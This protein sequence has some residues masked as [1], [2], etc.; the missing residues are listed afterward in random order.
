MLCGLYY[1][2]SFQNCKEA[3]GGFFVEKFGLVLAGGG[4]KGAYQIGVWRAMHEMGIEKLIGGVAG[5]SVG[6]IN[7]ALYVAGSYEKAKMLWEHIEQDDILTEHN[8]LQSIQSAPDLISVVIGQAKKALKGIRGGFFSRSGLTRLMR[9]NVDFDRIKASKMPFYVS[10]YN[11]DRTQVDYFDVRNADDN[12]EIEK[13]ILAS[14]ALPVVFGMESLRGFHY[15][16]GGLGDNCPVQPLYDLGFRKFIVV[17][18]SSDSAED[19]RKYTEKFSDSLLIN[20]VPSADQGNLITGTLDFSQEGI[21]RRMEQGYNDAL[22]TFCTAFGTCDVRKGTGAVTTTSTSIL[23]TKEALKNAIR[24]INKL[25]R[26]SR[27]FLSSLLRK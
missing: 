5:T 14:S 3:N 19:I 20:V 7:G 17:W 23:P 11:L 10:A 18:L 4:G 16:D 24:I 25:D 27:S 9:E 21:R 8:I 13:M 26:K 12:S 22:G 15:Y 1:T 6:A 2:N